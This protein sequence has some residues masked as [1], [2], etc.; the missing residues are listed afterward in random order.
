MKR[1]ATISTVTGQGE[2][3]EVTTGNESSVPRRR[4]AR[5]MTNERPVHSHDHS[6]DRPRATKRQRTS[7]PSDSASLSDG[8]TT[9]G[10]LGQGRQPRQRRTGAQGPK[11]RLPKTKTGNPGPTERGLHLEYRPIS[12]IRDMFGDLVKKACELG[13]GSSPL[14]GNQRPLRIATMCSGTESP[15]LACRLISEELKAQTDLA[16]RFHH[17]FSAEIVAFKQ[18]YIEKN[19][20]P[21]IL[22]RDITQLTDGDTASTAYGAFVPIPDKVDI[23]IAGFSCVD[24]SRLNQWPKDLNDIGESGDTFRGILKYAMRYRP[25]L[26]ILENVMSA[27]WEELQAIWRNDV[28]FLEKKTKRKWEKIWPEGDDAYAAHFVT[29]DTK[30]YYLPQTRQRGYMICIDRQQSDTAVA[31]VKRWG[32][33][34]VALRREASSPV[35]AFLLHSE[36]ARLHRAREE[37][38]ASGTSKLKTSRVVDWTLCQARYQRYRTERDLGY[39]RPITNWVNGGSCRAP[40]FW[41]LDWTRVQVERLWDTF[42]IC[43]LRNVLR[44]IDPTY[45]PRFWELSQNVDR[46]TDSAP[47]GIIGCLTPSGIPF[48]TS[49]GGPITGLEAMSLQGLPIDQL[50]LTRE[51][52]RELLDLAGNAMSSTVVG[53]AILASLIVGGRALTSD[54]EESDEPVVDLA[55][56]DIPDPYKEMDERALGTKKPLNLLEYSH[57]SVKT[58]HKQARNSVRLCYCEGPVQVTERP[59]LVCRECNHTACKHCAGIPSHSYQGMSELSIRSRIKPSE[60]IKAIKAELPMRLQFTGLDYRT[61]KHLG[62]MFMARLDMKLWGEYLDAVELALRDELRF[63][64]VTRT[65]DWVISYEARN[66]HLSLTFSEHHVFWQLKAKPN[67]N[68][69]ADSE[70]RKLLMRP[71]AS[72]T[73]DNADHLFS[74]SWQFFLPTTRTVDLRIRGLGELTKC[75]ESK[76]GLEDPTVVDKEVWPTLQISVSTDEYPQLANEIAGTYQL[77]QNCGTASGSLHKKISNRSRQEPIHLFLDPDRY[78]KPDRD[79]FVFSRDIHQLAYGETRTIIASMDPLWRPSNRISDTTTCK[80]LGEEI[81]CAAVLRP[82]ATDESPTC[83]VLSE[84]I[85]DILANYL[86][87]NASSPVDFDGSCRSK[88]HTILSCKVPLGAFEDLGWERGEW[89]KVDHIQERQTFALFAWLTERVRTLSGFSARWREVRSPGTSVICQSCAPRSPDIKWRVLPGGREK[90]IPFEDERQ[91]G[92][93]ERSIKARPAP[94]VTYTRID[95]E[96]RGCLMMGLNIGTLVH[97]ALAKFSFVAS[98]EEIKVSWRLDSEYEWPI[99]TSFPAFELKS[100]KTDAEREHKFKAIPERLELRREQRRSLA[101]MLAQESSEAPVFH[102]QETE[103]ALLATIGWRAEV[104]ATRP[105]K[106]RGGVLTDEVGYGKTVTTLA[107]IAKRMKSAIDST[108]IPR[109]NSIPVQATLIIVP[110]TLIAQWTRQIKRFLGQ[111]CIFVVIK[112][113]TD[114][115]S[116]SVEKIKRAHIVLLAWTI[117]GSDKYPPKI[118]SFA[119]MPEGPNAGGRAFKSW[120][121]EAS[122]RIGQNT[123][124]LKN[125]KKVSN[126]REALHKKLAEKIEENEVDQTVPTKRLKGAAYVKA[127]TKG[128]NKQAPTSA[129]TAGSIIDSFKLKEASCL[130]EMKSPPLQMFHFHRLVVDEYTYVNTKEFAYV[131][132]LKSTYRWVL[133]GTPRLGDFADVKVLAGFLGVH[134]GEDDD[135]SSILQSYNLKQ[136]RENR[137]AAE[138]FRAF[139][140]P[141]S[142]AWHLHRH[143]HAQDFLDHFARKNVAEIGVIPLVE[144]LRVVTLPP[145]QRALFMELQQ[146]LEAQ[147]MRIIR[148]GRTKNDGDRVKRINQL[149]RASKSAEEAL[150]KCAAF[151]VLEERSSNSGDDPK[152]ARPT[153]ENSSA[154]GSST[155]DSFVD[156]ASDAEYSSEATAPDAKENSNQVASDNQDKAENEGKACDLII[157]TRKSQ[158]QD[159]SDEFKIHLRHAVWLSRQ[160]ETPPP[161]AKPEAHYKSW[162][163]GVHRNEFGDPD[164]TAEMVRLIGDAE[165]NYSQSDEDE[166]YRDKPTEEEIRR[167]RLILKKR[168]AKDAAAKKREKA[169]KKKKAK[170]NADEDSE[171]SASDADNNVEDDELPIISDP[172][173]FKITRGDHSKFVQTLRILTG[174]LRVLAKELT[175][176]VR[177]LRFLETVKK[178][179]HW[180]SEERGEAVNCQSCPKQTLNHQ[181]PNP[182]NIRVLGLCGHVACMSCLMHQDRNGHCLVENCKAPAEEHHIHPAQDFNRKDDLNV[183]YGA[184]LDAIIDLIKSIPEDD[185]VLLFVQFE[186][187]MHSVAGALKDEDITYYAIFN[188]QSKNAGEEMDLFQQDVSDERKKVLILNPSNESAAGINLTNANHVIFVAP[189]LA[190]TSDDYF[191]SWTQCVGRARRYGQE[192]T[193]FVYQFLAL[194]TIDVDIFQDRMEKRLIN[195]GGN[196]FEAIPEKLLDKSQL[197]VNWGTGRVRRDVFND[198]DW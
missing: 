37:L 63:Q 132:S 177:A 172:R 178:L 135:C 66:S 111:S 182:S 114:L 53:A 19:F 72:M 2:T 171:S 197:A 24:F 183:R 11:P 165:D 34:M 28:E 56:R 126:F 82:F 22:F 74:G 113:M 141:R 93:F 73:V 50:L 12:N 32:E 189:L 191:A 96:R 51:S 39:A 186:D 7:S 110:K 48:A 102:E 16:F 194:N 160:C 15:L 88:L 116:L 198:E 158:Y 118:A 91:A 133:S 101:W 106:G 122:K 179:Q 33:L 170:G 10:D 97:R 70:L 104:R 108:Q 76:L 103:E 5:V 139:G 120:I 181:N 107:L 174:H 78:G 85:D 6:A 25:R 13:L 55:S 149:L 1:K 100:N 187:L 38:T 71:F 52:Q 156:L 81:S 130:D 190:E 180:Q 35:E 60:F 164:G 99:K 57:N 4:S 176:R 36:D 144:S 142:P 98:K 45:K 29:L 193:V 54:N 67:A 143:R 159:L 168:K 153:I 30:Q 43:F 147:D 115:N 119:A 46:F 17:L 148:G 95:E 40:D 127:A 77:L 155:G 14:L 161:K 137:T 87:I 128:K 188:S 94:F 49:R 90:F 61:M 129:S 86:E 80:V 117:F 185:Q 175:S 125:S 84:K 89:K 65:H 173:A 123:N 154:E 9:S 64:A 145:T 3:L 47:P 134:L 42:D 169:L 27:P 68:L 21:K 131:N 195:T 109:A 151:F 44:N 23:L 75:W 121:E 162:K 124:E 31:D 62:E 79:C 92:A 192:K 184:K 58:L 18:A 163:T 140:E 196:V 136:L 157:R 146:Q 83:E 69:P 20:Q 150:L 105:S 152:K 59:I 166:F 112:T 41:W 26:I 8:S 138:Q 167:E